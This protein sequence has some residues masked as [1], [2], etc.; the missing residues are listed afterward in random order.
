MALL[1]MLVHALSGITYNKNPLP[2]YY[3]YDNDA[4]VQVKSVQAPSRADI[5]C[6]AAMLA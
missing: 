1:M 6:N 2:V 5:A 4:C 3:T